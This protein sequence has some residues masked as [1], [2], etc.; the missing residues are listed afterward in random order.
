MELEPSATLI[1][2][3]NVTIP[4]ARFKVLAHDK[5][6][7][8]LDAETQRF[9]SIGPFFGRQR[10]AYC[11]WC[12]LPPE[13]LCLV[14]EMAQ[15]LYGWPVVMP[16]LPS[17]TNEGEH[18]IKNGGDYQPGWIVVTHVCSIWREVAIGSAKLWADPDDML[19]M[20]WT[21]MSM[22]IQRSQSLP[23]S[24]CLSGDSYGTLARM[25]ARL[26]L[27]F[28]PP[29]YG[30]LQHLNLGEFT[31][32]AYKRVAGHL[33]AALPNLRTLRVDLCLEETEDAPRLPSGIELSASLT[34]LSLQNCLPPRWDDSFFSA[35]IQ[36]LT[37][38]Y[39]ETSTAILPS[40]MQLANTLMSLKS[41][42][43]LTVV[44]AF[45]DKSS[46]DDS[47]PTIILPTSLRF[48]EVTASE[49]ATRHRACCEFLAHV[50]F[51]CNVELIIEINDPDDVSSLSENGP[52]T[53]AL[54]AI[55]SI[56]SRL[57]PVKALVVSDTAFLTHG[58]KPSESWRGQL[59]ETTYGMFSILMPGIESLLAFSFEAPGVQPL[60]AFGLPIP[61]DDLTSIS[62]TAEGV[63]IVYDSPV[64]WDAFE[65]AK[66]VRTLGLCIDNYAAVLRLAERIMERDGT[67]HPFFP[68]LDS[69][70]ITVQDGRIAK[71]PHHRPSFEPALHALVALVKDRNATGPCSVKDIVV[72]KYL[73]DWWTWDAFAI[74]AQVS[75]DVFLVGNRTR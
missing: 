45:P 72:D 32:P 73:R 34:A 53:L 38:Q 9:Q 65:T 42:E 59:I 19:A 71:D 31:L 47:Y 67:R 12:S 35:R 49:Y 44:D 20:S 2:W 7:E 40:A 23:F 70:C 27:C 26:P 4:S 39:P 16:A 25:D 54:T 57:R 48:C 63:A 60:A 75:F 15:E 56:Y 62:L 61:L 66:G 52:P 51:P 3:L 10:N 55:Q 28:A 50:V 1:A 30:R 8:L 13:V 24:L 58:N 11:R 64:W 22:V 21:L 68:N 41:L 69:I 6:L 29:M 36:R 17:G 18:A 74:Y 46:L 33:D 43:V 14:F 37:L 5:R